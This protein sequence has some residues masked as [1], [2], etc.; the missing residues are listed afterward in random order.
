MPDHADRLIDA[1]LSTYG[2]A[3]PGLEGRVMA[4]VA[5]ERRPAFHPG[6]MVWA[7]LVTVA[8]TLLLLGVFLSLRS[9]RSIGTQVFIPHPSEQT[10]KAEVR[11]DPRDAQRTVKSRGPQRRQQAGDRSA[12]AALPKEEMFP[13]PQPLSPEELALAQFAAQAPKA[14]RKSFIRAQEHLD[15]PIRI[16]AIRIDTTQI[17]PL[18]SPPLGSN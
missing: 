15:E 6:R 5:G 17:P 2:D 16:A 8:A 10:P 11:M 14:E 3:D 12:V 7:G 4:R 18:E 1:A 13:I 9:R